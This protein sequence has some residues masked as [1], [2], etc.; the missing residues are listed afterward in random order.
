MTSLDI[1]DWTPT[2]HP[3]CHPLHVD[4]DNSRSRLALVARTCEFARSPPIRNVSV[5]FANF[6][7]EVLPGPMPL[8]FRPQPRVEFR[9]EPRVS[10]APASCGP[11]PLLR[12]WYGTRRWHVTG[13]NAWPDQQTCSIYAILNYQK[14]SFVSWDLPRRFLDACGEEWLCGALHLGCLATW[15]M[16]GSRRY[17]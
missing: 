1:E 14:H 8:K 2:S 11:Q 6:A 5:I 3:L 4:P 12:S 16:Q 17:C 9:S 15:L 10:R 7:G 13:R